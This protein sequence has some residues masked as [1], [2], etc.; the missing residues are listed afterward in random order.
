MPPAQTEMEKTAGEPGEPPNGAPDRGT[1]AA[2]YGLAA[3]AVVLAAGVKWTIDPA[4]E[5]ESPFLLFI[6]AIVV[7]AWF[8]GLGAGLFAT[9][10]ALV[11]CNYLFLTPLYSFRIDGP[12][13]LLDL[14]LFGGV[15]AGIS[16]LVAS[17]HA[18]RHRSAASERRF[19]LLVQGAKDYA[20]LMLSPDGRVTSWNEGARRILC[21]EEAEILGEHFSVFFTPEDR[22]EGRPE[23]ELRRAVEGETVSEE[24]WAVRRDGSRLWANGSM[25][26]VRDAEGNLEGV[27]K[28][29]RDRTE[30]R[31][32]EEELRLKDRALAASAN[33]VVITDPNRP[34]DPI[35]YVNPAFVEITGYPAAEALGRNC[36]FL[37]GEDRDQP[38]LDGLRAAIREGE[39]RRVVLRNYRKDGSLFYNELTVSPV[40]DEGGR[41]VR[42]VGVLN[43]VTEGRRTEDALH[44]QA[45][46]SEILA[47]PLSYEERLVGLARLVVPRLADWC[48]VDVVEE[49]GAV[50][51]LAVEHE[52]PEKVALAYELQRRYPTPPDA[53]RGVPRVLETGEP[54]MV[55]EI[56]DEFL[57]QNV[58]DG[59]QLAMLRELGLRSYMIVPM[60][61]RGRTLGAITLVSA[62]S[63]RRYGPEDLEV[64]VTLVRRAAMA[65]ENARLY[66]EA[67]REIAERE[68]AQVELRQSEDRLRLAT[69]ATRLG[70]FDYDPV[71]GELL[72]D[73]RCKEIF[74]LPPD[75]EVDFD[76]FLAGL[77]PDDRERAASA[78]RRALDPA[79]DEAFGLE[80]RVVGLGNGEER[81]VEARGRA[82]FEGGRAVR[83]IGTVL[84]VTEKK[85]AGEAL[86]RSEERYR[87]VIEQSTEGIYLLD[88]ESRRLLETNH[89]FQKMFGYTAEELEGIEIYDLVAHS[90]EN[91]DANVG[92]TLEL[93]R[94]LIGERSYR[95]KDGTVVE[96]EIGASIISY[97]GQKAI[98][99]TV[100]DITA[101]KRAE[102]ALRRSE[103]RFRSLV[104]Y[105]SDIIVILAGDGE[106]LYE[107]PAVERVLG[108]TVEER[109]GTNAFDYLHPED[110]EPVARR[111]ADLAREPGARLS[112]EYRVRDKDGDWRH[113]EAVGVNRLEDPIIGGI[114]VNLRD[115][116][117]RRRSERALEEIREAERS[118]IARE[119]HDGVL[120]DL[121]YTAQAMEITR[122][123][124]EGTDLA[125]DLEE[126]A[127]AIRRAARDLR[128]AIYDL[129]A[130]RDGTT[131][132]RQLFG[133]LLDLSRR[134]MPDCIIAFDLEEGLLEGLSGRGGTELLRIVQ[135]ALTN[136]RRH[137]GARRVNVALSSE[138]GTL[139][140]EVSDDGR[141]FDPE[142]LP[143]GVGTLGMRER[144]LGLGGRIEVESEPGVG[145][146]VRLVAPLGNLRR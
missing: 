118:R 46:A 130:Y 143:P 119:L 18:A 48:A 9:G 79:V 63:G 105:A 37:Q 134:R 120:Q 39:T 139:R 89:A 84:D 85:R 111:F 66:E 7:G 129:R 59:R 127:G 81:W 91:V 53:P 128:E 133:S 54:E 52:D 38:E 22:R 50:R 138:D 74:G 40:P 10:L 71:T 55:G 90:R 31:R 99:A 137:S 112:A 32:A 5:A 34:D 2:R 30:A 21:Y 88:T 29:L 96:V 109:V 12:G 97:D 108:F 95:R 75:A 125:S 92:R 117:E 93:G 61:A 114:V 60:I 141:G 106:I 94:V 14:L 11:V 135:E 70:T 146:T 103:E 68:R 15:G 8:G 100:R 83:F 132:L 43:D 110:R 126:G 113:F 72:W 23:R 102:E 28:V 107:S 104:R 76:T 1:P 58:R 47:T 136:V 57:V 73:A 13:H 142:A 26:A 65:V 25:E 87:A 86:K 4:L 69:E 42:L 67:Q 144:A 36:R 35:V 82:F 17:M 131:D 145:T 44:V 64:A 49:D 3:V 115:V 16:A 80:Y 27:V 19:R 20:I 123:K 98:C 41:T 56:P 78:V 121:S 33:G 77:H 45:E 140:A 51:R 122:M 24:T 101:R 6:L 116:T 62:E 124:C